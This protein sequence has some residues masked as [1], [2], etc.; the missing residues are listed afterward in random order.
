MGL[1][2]P[3]TTQHFELFLKVPEE[4]GSSQLAS[5][6]GKR[7][8]KTAGWGDFDSRGEGGGEQFPFLVKDL[9]F[10]FVAGNTEKVKFAG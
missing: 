4:V 1:T 9:F 7:M 5:W 3:D 6:F 2:C 10:L 8:L